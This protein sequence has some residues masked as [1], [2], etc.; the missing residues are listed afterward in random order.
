[1]YKI[2]LKKND[3][4]NQISTNVLTANFDS[5]FVSTR[6]LYFY[7]YAMYIKLDN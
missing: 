3:F 1:M 6:V 4:E 5:T 7:T 2:S